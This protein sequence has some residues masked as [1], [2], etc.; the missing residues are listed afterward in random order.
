MKNEK[1]SLRDLFRIA[2]GKKSC[3]TTSEAKDDCCRPKESTNDCCNKD[4]D[5]QSCCK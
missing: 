5:K 3:C 2:G 4:I 1:V